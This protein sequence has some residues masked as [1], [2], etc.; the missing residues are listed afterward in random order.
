MAR[1]AATAPSDA[2]TSAGGTGEVTDDGEL[3]GG[4]GRAEGGGGFGRAGVDRAAAVRRRQQR[5]AQAL[6]G[7]HGCGVVV[8]VKVEVD[9]LRVRIVVPSRRDVARHT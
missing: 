1:R 8:E 3:R 5:R 6:G 4:G 9:L 7:R 2:V